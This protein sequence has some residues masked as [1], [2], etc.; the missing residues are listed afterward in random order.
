MTVLT[1]KPSGS[2]RRVLEA[3]G[4]TRY[5]EQSSAA[6]ARMAANPTPRVSAPHE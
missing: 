3:L 6:T 1:N 5:F 2:S 4:L